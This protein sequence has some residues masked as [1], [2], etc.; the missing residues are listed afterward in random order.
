MNYYQI[1]LS[2]L[3]LSALTYQSDENIEPYT[4]VMVLLRGKKTLGYILKKVEKPSFKTLEILQILPKKLTEIQIALL[5]FISYYYVSNLSITA[6]LFTPLEILPKPTKVQ[7]FDKIPK[8]SEAQSKA[9]EFAKDHKSSLIFG[10]TGSGKSE[11]Y[12]SLISEYLNNGK[13]V[14]L[15]MPEISLTPQMTK[16]LKHY[17]GENFGVWH[18][19]VTQK[20][21]DEI[22]AKFQSREFRLIA[23]A[24]SALFLP[25]SDLGLII[26]DE[27]HDESYKSAQNP[28]YNARDLALFLSSKFDLKVVLGS[29]TPSL[30]TYAKQPFFRLKGTFFQAQKNFIYD[31][32]ETKISDLILTELR[33]S[34]ERKKQA[35]VFLPTRA[36]FRFLACKDCANTIKCPFCSIGMSFYKRQN[37]LKCQ[38]C[39]FSSSVPNSCEKCGSEMIEAKKIGT[40]EVVNL[41]QNALPLCK[42]AK[43]DR[44]E[45]TTQKKL[46]NSLKAFNSREIDILVG[47]Q[48]LSKGHDYHN[49][50]LAVIMGVD[51]LLNFPDFR[52]RER[53]LALA[54]QVAGRAGRAG[55]GRVVVQSRQREFF[56]NF[57]NDYDT[58]LSDEKIYRNGLYPPFTRLVRAVFSNEDQNLAEQKTKEC[59]AV[60]E[61]LAQIQPD[62]QIIGNGKCGIE[63]LGGKYRF[64]I[65]MR[66]ISHKPL[67]KAAKI[68]YKMGF[69]V[70][71]DPLNFS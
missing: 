10:D 38:Y 24:R 66:S 7:N 11:I 14:L 1:L 61:N 6:G 22:L 30:T 60:L 69:D 49:V 26:V 36:N 9:L 65:L 52:A 27:E 15:L 67:L 31:E 20:K 62:L 42:I 12:F 5:E 35:V 2:G 39:G 4:Q 54:M 19:K 63:I 59:V 58:F 56:E 25:F 71:V 43:F 41:L 51:E 50:D 47:T 70:D 17:F 16:R 44:D 32:S 57:I 18:S 64:E 45:I 37:L 8:L 34:L 23:G 28:H 21:R 46:E 55:E 48:M 29:A 33:C 40:D 13:Q 53:A 3:N 68:C